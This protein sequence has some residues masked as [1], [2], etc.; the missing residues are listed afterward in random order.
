MNEKIA[1]TE[2]CAI[3]GCKL[4]RNGNYAT[5]TVE[6]RAHATEHHLVAKR[7]FGKSGK[8]GI[9]EK[10]PWKLRGEYKVLC[11]ECH[12]ILLHNPVFTPED[13]VAFAELVKLRKLDEPAKIDSYEKLAM[14]VQLLHEVIESGIKILKKET[15]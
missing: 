8:I 15:K 6:G 9:F 11:Y 4:N 5:S 7:F 10:C 3:C 14:R 12:E 2:K 13:I 1:E